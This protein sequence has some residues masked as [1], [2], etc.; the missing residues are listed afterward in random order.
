M[1]AGRYVTLNGVESAWNFMLNMEFI[2][3]SRLSIY[4]KTLWDVEE[5]E[6]IAVIG[7]INA[8]AGVGIAWMHW[9]EA[10]GT[11]LALARFALEELYAVAHEYRW[12]QAHV[13]LD[14]D[15]ARKFVWALGFISVSIKYNYGP[16]G[17]N[18]IEV[19]LRKPG[20]HF[21]AATTPEHVIQRVQRRVERWR[22]RP[23]QI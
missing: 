4:S 8:W 21:G 14:D 23:V 19:R 20:E 12:L 11:R 16:A 5:R 15:R 7:I 6:A 10:P 17:E 13:R 22:S 3:S 1:S 18:L 2:N 9:R